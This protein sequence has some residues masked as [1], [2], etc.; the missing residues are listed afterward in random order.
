MR[1]WPRGVRKD[2]VDAWLKD[3][4]P[5][6]ELLGAYQHRGLAWD[7]FASQY[8]KEI[9]EERSTVLKE[10]RQ[11]SREHGQVTLLCHERLARDEHC[12]RLILL[13]LL[14]Q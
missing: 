7:D 1:R 12:H 13:E 14:I 11:L 4:A 8:R 6:L 2:R 5:S 10:L 3:A 9:L